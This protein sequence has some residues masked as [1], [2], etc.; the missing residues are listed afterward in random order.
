MFLIFLRMQKKMP[1]F[2]IKE[3]EKLEM[4]LENYRDVIE[5]SNIF[6]EDKNIKN[7]YKFQRNVI[8]ELESIDKFLYKIHNLLIQP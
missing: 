1:E 5:D 8:D 6:I 2:D 7:K 3:L 4:L